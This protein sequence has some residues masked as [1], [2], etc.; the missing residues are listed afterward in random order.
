MIVIDSE[1]T[2][3]PLIPFLV[4]GHSNYELG[5]KQFSFTYWNYFWELKNSEDYRIDF[6]PQ[7]EL[8]QMLRN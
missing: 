1:L 2:L 5:S 6:M 7:P 3:L 8:L 4:T